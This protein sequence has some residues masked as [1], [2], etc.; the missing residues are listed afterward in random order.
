MSPPSLMTI[1]TLSHRV[2]RGVVDPLFLV[3]TEHEVHH[4]DGVASR[5]LEQVVDG[6]YGHYPVPPLVELEPHVAEVGAYHDLRVRKPERSLPVLHHPDER[7]VAILGAVHLP[8]GGVL[9]VPLVEDVASGEDAPHHVYRVGGHR[10]GDPL[11]P[12]P[13]EL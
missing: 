12:E 7:L 8:D 6:A 9:D 5:S 11:V 2:Q 10:H 3:Q 1:L 13:G 4:L